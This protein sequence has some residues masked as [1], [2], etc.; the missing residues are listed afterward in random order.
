MSEIEQFYADKSIFLTGGTG[1]L[2]KILIEKLLRSCSRL[3]KIYVLIRPNS[4]NNPRKRLDDLFNC[5]VFKQIKENRP[6]LLSKVEPINGN[7][8]YPGL[9]ISYDN[10]ITLKNEV[11]IVLHSA[12]TIRFDEPL[13]KAL[14]INLCGTESVI[15]FCNQL[16]NLISFVHISTAYC[17]TVKNDIEEKVY[18]HD[19]TVENVLSANRWMDA[20]LFESLSEKLYCGRPSSYHYTKALAESLVL[21]N[22]QKMRKNKKHY[23]TAIIRPSIVTPTLKEPLPGWTNNYYGPT[24]YLVVAGKGVLRSMIVHKDKICDIVPVDVVANTAITAAHYISKQLNIQ[25]DQQLTTQ[26][27]DELKLS[28]NGSY[29]SSSADVSDEDAEFAG[30]SKLTNGKIINGHHLINGHQDKNPTNGHSNGEKLTNGKLHTSSDEDDSEHDSEKSVPTIKLNGLSRTSST[31]S[32]SSLDGSLSS[33][34]KMSEKSFDINQYLTV[35]NCI[36]GAS[37]PISWGEIH[38]LCEPFLLKY[39]SIELFRYPGALLHSNKMLHQII[40]QLEHNIPAMLIDFIFKLLGHKPIL[41]PVYEK[42]HRS[43]EALEHFTTNEWTWRTDNFEKL[44]NSQNEIDREKFFIDLQRLN[45]KSYMENYILGVRYY[46]LRED[47][48]TIP[49]ARKKLNRLYYLT[50]IV[51]LGIAGGIMHQAI[52]RYPDRKSVV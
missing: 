30:N 50:Q 46:L 14:E 17:N 32:K 2:G 20:D 45:W 27:G 25:Q 51:K 29:A 36:S 42:V 18:E 40:L 24:G 26:L 7:I 47:P 13:K 39:P 8:T 6:D 1:F 38:S 12:A 43:I 9:G 5:E 3:K 11:N 35:F 28:L 31:S 19:V 33:K 37:N 34:Y 4:S 49:T 48:S 41:T 22:A 15:N 44:I 52:T 23:K 21:H 10:M 16:N